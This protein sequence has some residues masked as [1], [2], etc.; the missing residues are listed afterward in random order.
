MTKA[1]DMAK[2]AT[3]EEVEA[4]CL[5]QVEQVKASVFKRGYDV[6]LSDAGVSEDSPLWSNYNTV[7]P[8]DSSSQLAPSEVPTQGQAEEVS[9]PKV[10]D[11]G[12]SSPVEPT[13]PAPS[14]P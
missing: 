1:I 8:S 6:G 7:Q 10:K 13:A 5:E 11:D 2:D 3:F 9:S 12:T 14:V 4:V